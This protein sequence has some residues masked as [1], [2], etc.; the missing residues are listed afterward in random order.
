MKNT[1]LTAIANR[2][3]YYGL[4]KDS[5][6]TDDALQSLVE[7]SIKHTPSAM[8]A[9]ITRVV[10]LHKR[11]PRSPLDTHQGRIEKSGARRP[12]L[13]HRQKNHVFSTSLRHRAL[14]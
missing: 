3:S 1:L 10:I 4:H 12:V 2:R 14:F 13:S 9:Q 5:P 8:N 6:L 7:E 11:G